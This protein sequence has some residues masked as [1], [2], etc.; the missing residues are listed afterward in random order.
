MLQP[1][2]IPE[3]IWQHV[4]LDFIEGLPNSFGEKVI[5]VVVER[6]SKA[7]HLIVLSHPYTASVMDQAYLDNILDYMDLR[8]SQMIEML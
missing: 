6:L 4:I 2:P 1:L 5:F 3:Y 7:A 8:L